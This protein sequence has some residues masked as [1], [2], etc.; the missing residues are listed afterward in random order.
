MTK[1]LAEKKENASSFGLH[2]RLQTSNLGNGR[3][4]ITQERKPRL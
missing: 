1:D 3:K 4:T 2:S